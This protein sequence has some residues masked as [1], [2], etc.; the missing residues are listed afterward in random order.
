M[1]RKVLS[2]NY[3]QLLFAAVLLFLVP[4]CAPAV[5][6]AVLDGVSLKMEP[7][8]DVLTLRLPFNV[9]PEHHRYSQP[10]RVVVTVPAVEASPTIHSIVDGRSSSR[11]EKIEVHTVRRSAVSAGAQSGVRHHHSSP[12]TLITAYLK[13]DVD[14]AIE[15][16]REEHLLVIHYY[17]VDAAALPPAPSQF[18]SPENSLRSIRFL[19]RESSETVELAFTYPVASSVFETGDPERLFLLLRRTNLPAPVRREI[20]RVVQMPRLFNLEIYNIGSQPFPYDNMNRDREY[21]FVDYPSPLAHDRFLRKVSGFQSRDAVVAVRPAGALLY[22]VEYSEDRKRV[23]LTVFAYPQ[24]AE[25]V[26]ECMLFYEERMPYLT[27]NPPFRA[28]YKIETELGTLHA[29]PE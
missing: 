9:T 16:D 24:R 21:H 25:P 27:T 7:S 19:R 23:F 22:N 14:V 1:S 10:N 15:V 6:R 17:R 18:P 2:Y 26:S 13:P 3:R 5:Q 28:P 20:R 29:V 11:V 8:S 4:A 12:A